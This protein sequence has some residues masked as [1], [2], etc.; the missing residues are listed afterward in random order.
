LLSPTFS[1][2]SFYFVAMLRKYTTTNHVA[3]PMVLLRKYKVNT[4]IASKKDG[5]P[6]RDVTVS[7]IW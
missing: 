7:G 4:G 6:D 2:L 1:F 5:C 3:C